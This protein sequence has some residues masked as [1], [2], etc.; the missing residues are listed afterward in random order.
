MSKCYVRNQIVIEGGAF[1]TMQD[2]VF[3]SL[4]VGCI[5]K[6]ISFH[7]LLVFAQAVIVHKYL[8]NLCLLVY[9]CHFC[10]CS[11]V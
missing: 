4:C 10:S 3:Y 6:V 8:C 1:F 11:P 2:N 7:F 9:P 5:G